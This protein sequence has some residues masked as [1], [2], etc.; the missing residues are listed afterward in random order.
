LAEAGVG[1]F[2]AALL[3]SSTVHPWYLLWPM[4]LVPLAIGGAGRRVGVAS[5][6]VLAWSV[7][8]GLAY[9]AIWRHAAGGPYQP[10]GWAVGLQYA[11]VYGTLVGAASRSRTRRG[12]AT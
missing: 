6:V 1:Y 8:V 5:G 3:L 9:T 7:G 12:R 10:Y 2:L 11:V 4:A